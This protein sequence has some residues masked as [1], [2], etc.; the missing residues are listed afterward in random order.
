MPLAYHPM[1]FATPAQLA[2][3]W[4]QARSTSLSL[5]ESFIDPST[6]LPIEMPRWGFCNPV[7]WELGHLA[8]FAE[9]FVL[10]EATSSQVGSARRASLLSYGDPT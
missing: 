4:L 3:S 1:R 8:W 5:F 10:R 9:W 6:N 7:L 2:D